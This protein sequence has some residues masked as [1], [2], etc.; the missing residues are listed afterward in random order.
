MKLGELIKNHRRENKLTLRDFAQRCGM[1]HSYISMLE[2]CK[3]S[4]TGEPMT[5]TLA[6][7]KKIAN[8]LNMSLNDLMTAAD[9]MPVKI[10]DNSTNLSLE[11][12][13]I[14]PITKKR[15]K[16]LGEIA[17]GSPIYADEDHESYIDASANIDADFCLVAKGDSM[18]GA[19]IYDGDVV[20]IKQQSIV[21]NGEIA[22]VI[23]DDEATL[24]TWYYYPDKQ[25]LV[26]S[27]ANQS[28]E[29]LVY[30]GPELDSVTCL[31]KAVCF[32][33]NL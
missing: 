12:L 31:G 15:F 11:S 27:P 26:L 14:R 32:M 9:D 25:K 33:S 20:F 2:E 4:K 16:V 17:C 29:P 23:I 24:K 21:T 19:R 1:S 8:A 28:Y 10:E 18:T 13:G 6:T 30:S 7:L 3:N 22:A 5:P